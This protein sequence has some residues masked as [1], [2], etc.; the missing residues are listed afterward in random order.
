M[1]KRPVSSP[2]QGSQNTR[3]LQHPLNDMGSG[4]YNYSPLPIFMLF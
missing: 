4:E 2:A 3:D 1:F